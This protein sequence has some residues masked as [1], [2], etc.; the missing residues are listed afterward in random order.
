MG[1]TKRD[2]AAAGRP[3][4]A[5]VADPDL[6]RHTATV[7]V[8]YLSGLPER[9]VGAVATRDDLLARLGGSVPDAGES[10]TAVI[11]DLV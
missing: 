11:D 6:L 5:A 9:R 1:T 8:D 3:R 4:A 7:A 10:T 2:D